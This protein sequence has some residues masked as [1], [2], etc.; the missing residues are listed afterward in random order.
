M[1]TFKKLIVPMSTLFVFG[2]LVQMLSSEISSDRVRSR[3]RGP[4][5]CRLRR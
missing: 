4:E 1:K 2:V 3:V 5:T